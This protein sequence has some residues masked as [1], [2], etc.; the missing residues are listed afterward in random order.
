[1]AHWTTWQA[2]T[3][4]EMKHRGVLLM[5]WLS[6][7]FLVLMLVRVL[8]WERVGVGADVVWVRTWV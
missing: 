3:P 2:K 1:M 5:V 4:Q 8:V 6:M 7:G